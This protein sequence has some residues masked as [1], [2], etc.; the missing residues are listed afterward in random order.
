METLSVVLR[1]VHHTNGET[2]VAKATGACPSFLLRNLRTVCHTH[3]SRT[4]Q[5]HTFCPSA[6]LLGKNVFDFPPPIT[7]N[8][9]K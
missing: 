2:D 6:V 7:Q 8:F 1:L 5:R 9:V 3:N 4:F